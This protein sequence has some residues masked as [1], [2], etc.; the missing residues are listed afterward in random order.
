MVSS[1]EE[2][3]GDVLKVEATISGGRRGCARARVHVCGFGLVSGFGEEELDRE[4]C[5]VFSCSTRRD[6]R[7][8]GR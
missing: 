6:T 5:V 8:F 4:R 2:M 7:D 1:S 3:F